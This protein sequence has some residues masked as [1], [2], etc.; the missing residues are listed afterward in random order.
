MKYGI[1][2]I[3]AIFDKARKKRTDQMLS[4]TDDPEP[5]TAWIPLGNGKRAIVD[6]CDFEFLNEWNWYLGL[7]GYAQT[8]QNDRLVRMHRLLL[9]PPEHLE[10]DHVNG[11]RLDNRKSNLRVCTRA[12]NGKN[13]RKFSR[14]T[15]SKYKGVSF[16]KASHRFIA[17]LQNDGKRIDLGYFDSEDNAARAYNEAASRLYGEFARLNCV[18]KAEPGNMKGWI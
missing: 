14:K 2:G 10:C 16:R 15:S 9:N 17:Y 18:P 1:P 6:R 11:D 7:E 3:Q 8:H 12:Q 13:C 5:G 4:W